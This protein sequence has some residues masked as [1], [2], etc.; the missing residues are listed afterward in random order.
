MCPGTQ[1]GWRPSQ[2]PKPPSRDLRGRGRAPSSRPG[3]RSISRARAPLGGAQNAQLLA[4]ANADPGGSAQQDGSVG[5]F[6]L[7]V[8]WTLE[9]RACKDSGALDWW[10]LQHFLRPPCGRAKACEAGQRLLV[11][12][13]APKSSF[14]AKSVHTETRMP[15][16]GLCLVRKQ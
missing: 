10:C 5:H 1:E 15:T 4:M 8:R 14:Q 16:W 7:S 2:S 3:L 12:V 11:A 13:R 6:V 9:S